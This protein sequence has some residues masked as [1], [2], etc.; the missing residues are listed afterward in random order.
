MFKCL[1]RYL[2]VFYDHTACIKSW[3]FFWT[4][5]IVLFSLIKNYTKT[6]AFGSDIYVSEWHMNGQMDRRYNNGTNSDKAYYLLVV[7]EWLFSVSI[8]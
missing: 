8:A 7:Y 6:T 3:G 1:S 2:L 5:Y 4:K